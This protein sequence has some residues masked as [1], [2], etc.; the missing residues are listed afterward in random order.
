M[1][2]I[3]LVPLRSRT[4][5]HGGELGA[6]LLDPVSCQCQRR[7]LQ[8]DLAIAPAATDP[9]ADQP[10]QIVV[11]SIA[12]ENRSDQLLDVDAFEFATDVEARLG[13]RLLFLCGRKCR[14]EPRHAVGWPIREQQHLRQLRDAAGLRGPRHAATQPHEPRRIDNGGIAAE[15]LLRAAQERLD[16]RRLVR[17][18]VEAAT[19]AARAGA[20]WCR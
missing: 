5:D 15:C 17:R 19:R 8:Q 9:V 6:G 13:A 1:L 11:P 18:L 7:G 14:C 3:R 12:G 2:G 20:A 4:G 16:Q 10:Q